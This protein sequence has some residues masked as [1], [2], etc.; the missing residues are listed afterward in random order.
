MRIA[1]NLALLAMLA[2]A[3]TGLASPAALAQDTEPELHNQ[4][5]RLLVAQEAHGAPDVA[6]PAVTPSPPPTPS[7][8]VTTGGCRLHVASGAVGLLTHDFM[9]VEY[10]V[11]GCTMEFDVR[12]DS[13]GEGWLSHQE[14]ANSGGA[15]V[16]GCG[17]RACGQPNQ[18]GE[19]R[20]YSFYLREAEAVGPAREAGTFLMCFLDSGGVSR[21]CEFTFPMSQPAIHRY[22]FLADTQA[23]HGGWTPSCPEL[24]GI[25]STEAGG[26]LSGEGLAY[27][28]VEIRHT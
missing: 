1:R 6:C 11:G 3:A 20:A 16:P 24:D 18:T 21:H 22:H 10:L 13:A 8:L 2:L 25:L 15:G 26:P 7:P 27:Q 23:P 17:L 28:N 9:G 12:I 5:P 14:F 4:T 19:G